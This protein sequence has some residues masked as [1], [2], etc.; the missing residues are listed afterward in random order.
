MGDVVIG[1]LLRAKRLIPSTEQRTDY[2]I[3]S[4]DNSLVAEVMSVAAELRR[5]DK[6]FEYA[7]KPQQL[8]RQLKAASAAGADS[9]VL[10]ERDAF[11]RGEVRLKDLRAGTERTLALGD[12]INSLK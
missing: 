9:A 11:E 12:L 3:A 8:S 1:E 5:R 4:D 7:L 10:L 6:I 2:W